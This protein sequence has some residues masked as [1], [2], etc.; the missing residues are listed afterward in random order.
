M[1]FSNSIQL[2]GNLGDSPEIKELESGK[3]VLN[4]SIATNE[5]R[6]DT[7]GTKITTTHWHRIVAW[8]NIAETI[9]KHVK[10]GEKV[11]LRGVLGYENWENKDG[12][13]M[14]TAQITVTE[15]LLMNNRK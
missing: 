14:I 4:F 6:K 12:V 2:I 10:K 11:G 8:G 9:S 1:G 7:D 13:K 3:K 15:L 5:V